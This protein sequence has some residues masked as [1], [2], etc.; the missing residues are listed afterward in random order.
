MKM[1]KYE[2][3]LKPLAS[4]TD[5]SFSDDDQSGDVSCIFPDDVEYCY[6]CDDDDDKYMDDDDCNINPRHDLS[7]LPRVDRWLNE[8]HQKDGIQGKDSYY[9]TRMKLRSRKWRILCSLTII[10]ILGLIWAIIHLGFRRTRRG[11]NT[12]FPTLP[13]GVVPTM[14]PTTQSQPQEEFPGDVVENDH[15]DSE[16]VSS[17][18]PPFSQ[19][20]TVVLRPNEYLAAGQ[21]RSSPSGKYR[22]D[23]T[24]D[25]DLVLTHHG[26]TD[27]TTIWSTQTRGN[28]VRAYLQPDGNLLLRNAQRETLWSSQT[29]GYPG[30]HLVLSEHGQLSIQTEGSST[31]TVSTAIWMDGV[32]RS[33]YRGPAPTNKDLVFPVRGAFYYP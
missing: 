5:T 19:D 3:P 23:L 33:I 28:N 32:P 20:E 11:N 24:E 7:S 26:S 15:D 25:G 16:S 21:F 6:R 12:F 1:E 22:I 8:R 2:R 31:L 9:W 18:A 14:L 27:R 30:A 4:W 29:H 10:L 17:V 13:P